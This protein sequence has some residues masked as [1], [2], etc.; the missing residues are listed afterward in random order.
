MSVQPRYGSSRPTCE[1]LTSLADWQDV[2]KT[3]SEKNLPPLKGRQDGIRNRFNMDKFGSQPLSHS[4]CRRPERIS[5][6]EFLP[7][8]GHIGTTAEPILE[9]KTPLEHLLSIHNASSSVDYHLV[10]TC[11]N[12]QD[13]P[14][15]YH[16]PFCHLE[17]NDSFRI[18]KGVVTIVLSHQANFI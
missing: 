6:L 15:S 7:I 2:R 5:Y 13:I 11:K 3:E 10:E 1:L 8:S 12:L 17:Q 4:C 14:E 16:V 18:P 9:L